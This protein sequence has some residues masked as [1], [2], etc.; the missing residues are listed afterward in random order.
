MDIY[1]PLFD[2][3]LSESNIQHSV[4]AFLKGKILIYCKRQ[5]NVSNNYVNSFGSLQQFIHYFLD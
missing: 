2:K 3:S 4:L 1:H 5:N